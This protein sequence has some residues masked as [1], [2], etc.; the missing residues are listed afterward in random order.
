MLLIELHR[1]YD[2][3]ARGLNRY[4]ACLNQ[5]RLSLYDATYWALG[6]RQVTLLVLDGFNWHV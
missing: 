5:L 2:K 1:L 4:V 3:P 6:L